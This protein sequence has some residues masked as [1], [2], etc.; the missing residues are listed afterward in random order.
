M[1]KLPILLLLLGSGMVFACSVAWA[2][3][4]A[5]PAEEALIQDFAIR[6]LVV[7]DTATFIGRE[8]YD[9]FATAWLDQGMGDAYNLSVHEQPTAV[10][11]SRVWVQY[12]RETLFE[13]RLPPVRAN[14]QAN[15][16]EA[17]RSAARRLKTL[18][19]E[20]ALFPEPDLAP[21]EF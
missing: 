1:K 14:I 20:R 8:F 4:D 15:A 5:A 12:K 7:D 17:A 18:E 6:G 10:S 11:G 21:D 3:G 19:I 16:Q 2:E 13:V 9:A